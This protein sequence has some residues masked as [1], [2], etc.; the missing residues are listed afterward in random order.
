MGYNFGEKIIVFF[1]LYVVVTAPISTSQLSDFHP[2]E[3]G[4]MQLRRQ[5]SIEFL[6]RYVKTSLNQAF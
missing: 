5:K 3:E 4:H 1:L 2:F 6:K